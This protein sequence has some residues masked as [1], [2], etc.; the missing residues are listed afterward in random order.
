MT[1]GQICISIV[2]PALVLP[3]RHFAVI[4]SKWDF[5]AVDQGEYSLMALTGCVVEQ[6]FWV[7]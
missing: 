3:K 4:F 6:V 2:I 7:G 5:C 1:P